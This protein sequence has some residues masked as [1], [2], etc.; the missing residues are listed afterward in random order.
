MMSD[1]SDVM[2]DAAVQAAIRRALSILNEAMMDPA[3]LDWPNDA[4]FVIAHAAQTLSDITAL[5]P[6][7]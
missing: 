6:N 1:G 5:P 2:P 7:A 3:S 4:R